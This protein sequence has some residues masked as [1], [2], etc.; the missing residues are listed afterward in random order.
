[1][2]VVLTVLAASF[3][4]VATPV[5]HAGGSQVPSALAATSVTSGSA[6]PTY[7]RV[8]TRDRV[9]FITI[10]D[11]LSRPADAL[12]FVRKHHLPVTSFLTVSTVRGH[13][14]YFRKMSA[15]GSVQ[16]HTATHRDLALSSTDVYSEVCGAQR[17]FRRAFG[18]KPW[19]LRPPYGDL[20]SNN[21]VQSI[22]SG[23]GIR[24]LVLWDA[25]VSNTNLTTWYGGRL[26]RGSIILLHYTS[27]LKH[28]LRAAYNASRGQG[29]TPA[30][31]TDYLPAS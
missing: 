10:D 22:V 2:A 3:A 6:V 25:V 30:D 7:Y 13:E 26:M 28:D 17:Y 4:V 1:M 14:N 18:T 9:V 29:L 24:E 16:N 19:M 12:E 23:C 27:R 20:S 21:R 31:L 8:S 11:G 5:S 15:W